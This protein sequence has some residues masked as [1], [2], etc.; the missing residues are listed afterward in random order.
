MIRVSSFW[1]AVVSAT[2][3]LAAQ[4]T[5]GPHLLPR[6]RLPKI[7]LGK[8]IGA[9]TYPVKKSLVNGGK[10]VFKTAAA[11]EA[12]GVLPSLGP[13]SVNNAAKKIIAGIARH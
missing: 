12:L 13:P 2:L 1:L 3:L 9:L 4:A 10:T 5:A 8:G 11:T 6:L 7:N